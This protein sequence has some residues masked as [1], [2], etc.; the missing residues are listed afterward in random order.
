MN[1]ARGPCMEQTRRN[2]HSPARGTP[3]PHEWPSSCWETPVPGG[4]KPDLQTESAL[5][6]SMQRWP[7]A[8]TA[9]GLSRSQSRTRLFLSAGAPWAL[10]GASSVP[11]EG[12]SLSGRGRQGW[13]TDATWPRQACRDSGLGPSSSGLRLPFGVQG[14][15]SL[16]THALSRELRAWTEA[17]GGARPGLK[18]QSRK[19]E[20]EASSPRGLGASR[21][22]GGGANQNPG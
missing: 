17:Q 6:G 13:N 18:P 5:E 15:G 2:Q 7:R 9:C 1:S 16:H 10:G 4:P 20:E 19:Q 22:K 12:E 21:D 8:W 3:S 11:Q 14:A